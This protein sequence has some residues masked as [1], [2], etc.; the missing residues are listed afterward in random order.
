MGEVVVTDGVAD[1]EWVAEK[2][3]SGIEALTLYLRDS[4]VD[5]HLSVNLIAGTPSGSFFFT[6]KSVR[7]HADIEFA[8][9]D[10]HGRRMND[11]VTRSR[12]NDFLGSKATESFFCVFEIGFVH[13]LC[14]PMGECIIIGSAIA[15][16]PIELRADV[17]YPSFSNP[18]EYVGIEIV[19]VGQSCCG[20]A[21]KR[22]PGV[23]APDAERRDTELD[24]WF[25]CFDGFGDIAD[26]H[27]DVIS[28]PLADVSKSS[29]MCLEAGFIGKRKSRFGIWVEIVVHVYGVD[30]V[31]RD[32]IFDNEAYPMACF[33]KSGFE[34]PLF[35]VLPEPIGM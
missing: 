26:S 13:S 1:A 33:V 18:I 21:T 12:W 29:W 35:S 17:V 11:I 15:N 2:R 4:A 7:R 30:V 25:G 20:S 14:P 23:I 24:V 28:S 27:I 16:M 5:F 22:V 10:R 6:T 19:V 34:I 9:C 3:F 8:E 31:S 32:D